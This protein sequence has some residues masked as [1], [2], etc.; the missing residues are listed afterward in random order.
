MS[1]C[2]G[3]G[4]ELKPNR[5][6]GHPRKWCS[7]R[8]RRRTLYSG[9]CAD[10]GGATYDGTAHPP[11]RCTR[12]NG[13]LAGARQREAFREQRALVERLWA[14]GLT[15]RQIGVE[16]GWGMRHAAHYISTLRTQ[17]GYDLPYRRTPEQRA[18][19]TAGAEERLA[20]ARAVYREQKAARA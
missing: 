18:R 19:I 10:C 6:P 1:V 17:R 14:E 15:A 3:C 20:H 5:G 12:C 9:V 11:N 2:A 13:R 4:A 16:L 8:C 7:E